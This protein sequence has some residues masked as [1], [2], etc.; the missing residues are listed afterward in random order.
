[1]G[2]PQARILEGFAISFSRGSD[3][4][5]DQNQVSYI[6]GGFFTTE[7]KGS[8]VKKIKKMDQNF[9]AEK[10]VIAQKLETTP[11]VLKATGALEQLEHKVWDTKGQ[12]RR[13]EGRDWFVHDPVGQAKCL[14][15][16]CHVG[17]P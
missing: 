12:K 15:L 7:P 10:R 17:K 9:Q 6:A 11:C 8:Y 14:T 5:R 4:P 13:Y 16:F 3:Q 2:F 1:M